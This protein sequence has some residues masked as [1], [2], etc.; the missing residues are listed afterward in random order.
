MATNLAE[1]LSDLE[2]KLSDLTTEFHD[3]HKTITG[4]T[5]GEPNS[6]QGADGGLHESLKSA[7]TVRFSDTPIPPSEDLFGSYRDDPSSQS[8]GYHDQA[9]EMSNQQL[10]QYHAQIMEEQDEQ[11]DRLGESIGRQRQISMQ[12]GDELD[13][14]VTLLDEMDSVVDRHQSRLD[15]AKSVLG[16][17]L[18]FAA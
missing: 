18:E 5:S 2:Q 11:L 8:A 4:H 17:A 3:F 7:K 12:I 14:H 1:A 16:R 10:Q 9:Q 15:R 6:S 13:H